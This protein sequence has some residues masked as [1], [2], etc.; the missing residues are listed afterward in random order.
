MEIKGE[1]YFDPE[2]LIYKDHFPGNP[3]VPGSL[4][5]SS[6]FQA[7]KNKTS[8]IVQENSFKVEKFRFRKFV[9][10]GKYAY[11]IVQEGSSIQCCLYRGRKEFVQGTIK[12]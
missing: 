5:I 6:F 3:V 4:I 10:P 2:D 7:I 1:F 12:I 8:Y 11:S 9:L